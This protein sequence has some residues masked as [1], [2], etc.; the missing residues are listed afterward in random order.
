MKVNVNVFLMGNPE[1]FQPALF[2]R[3]GKY[4]HPHLF[5]SSLPIQSEAVFIARDLVLEADLKFQLHCQQ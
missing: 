1:N 2:G 5:F 4:P 3:P